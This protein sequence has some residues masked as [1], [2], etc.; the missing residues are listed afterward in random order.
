MLKVAAPI[1]VLLL[2]QQGCDTNASDKKKVV[3]AEKA[4]PPRPGLHR[5]VLTRL[6]VDIAFDT[7]TGQLCRTW[8]WQLG[9][10][11]SKPDPVTGTSPERR[12]GEYSPTCLSLYQ[13]YPSGGGPDVL[14]QAAPENQ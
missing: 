5:F 14:E 12:A 3:S 9:G 8:E 7:Q 1:A 13:Q 6:G 4:K 10:A 11:P 2:A